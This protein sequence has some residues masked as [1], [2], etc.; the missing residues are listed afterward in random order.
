MTIDIK[1]GIDFDNTIICYDYIF[2]KLGIEKKIIP[3]DLNIGK[4]YVRDF[5][6]QAGKEDDWTRL[7]GYVYGARLLDA[8]AYPDVT[9]FFSF[10]DKVSLRYCIVS[11][12]TEYP[13]DGHPY[14]LHRAAYKWLDQAGIQCDTFFEQTKEE[15]I[16]RINAEGCSHFIDDLPEFLSL[17][18]FS[19]D[20]IK[21]LFDPLDQYDN[22]VYSRT[23]KTVRSWKDIITLFSDEVQKRWDEKQ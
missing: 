3:Q 14:N 2:N 21:I 18:G 12:K 7:Q 13:Y 9:N 4:N 10:C 19:E 16:D 20:I 22:P 15:K 17:P 8:S 11:H 1:I 23:F 5:L 6:R